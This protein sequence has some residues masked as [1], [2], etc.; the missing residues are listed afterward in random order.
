MAH[1][2]SNIRAAGGW[3]AAA[4]LLLVGSLAPHPPPSPD[5]DTFMAIIA[6]AGTQWVVA[7]WGAAL[8]L[9]AFVVAGLI[10]LTARS[11]LTQSWWTI[12]AWAILPVAALWVVTTAVAEATVISHA[13]VAGDRE[14][15]QAWERFAE[16]KAMGFM[17]IA[18]AVAL[19]AAN[20]ARSGRAATPV[21]ACWAGMAAALAALAGWT[22]GAV[23]GIGA[24]GLVW[25]ASSLAMGLWTL[26]FGL[27]LT[28]GEV[29]VGG[30]LTDSPEEAAS[31]L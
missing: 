28:R 6:N 16:G 27:A 8:A 3:L 18:L 7:H 17:G 25:V 26:W 22:L 31:Q 19:I 14:A 29:E 4:S 1:T 30:R 15:F 2:D 12:S 23:L 11:R 10:V 13:A 24:G 5:L 9:S 21:W 20:E